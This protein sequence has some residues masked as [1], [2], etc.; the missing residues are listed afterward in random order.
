M[1]LHRHRVHLS[2]LRLNPG[3]VEA[4]EG[5]VKA[6]DLAGLRVV[7]EERNH[8]WL[9]ANHIVNEA[10]ERLF[11]ATLDKDPTAL[12]V[13]RLQ[14]LHPLHRRGDLELKGVLD[15]LNRG[16]VEVAGDVGHQGQG[17]LVDVQAVQHV[18]Q[19]LG[20]RGDDAGVEGVADRDALG[21]ETLG[22]KA[23]DGR[24]HGL[25]LAAD[26]CL[27]VAVDVRRHHVTVNLG[28]GRLHHIKRGHHRRHP[29]VVGHADAGH[30][31]TTGGGGLQRLGKGHDPGGHQGR[32]LAERVAHH[33][34][35]VDAV[36]RQELHHGDVEGEHGGLG[37]RRLHQLALGLLQHRRV[38]AIH[39]QVTGERASKNGRHHRV[40]LGEHGSDLGRNLGQLAAHVQ[41]L[42]ALSR[43]EHSHLAGG[44]AA[45]PVDSLGLE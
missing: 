17:W 15:P 2:W 28:Q 45:A 39:K 25:A 12:G 6:G 13:E 20:S 10:L 1:I 44:E 14:T 7:G 36:G 16:R 8:I 23:G 24:L 33:H 22:H 4:A 9:A 26:D 30:L 27:A 19:R 40:G 11:R 38:V 21:L 31:G 42:A 5:L 3:G 32:V 29:A 37:D 34:V 41:V 18:A 35:R 43:E